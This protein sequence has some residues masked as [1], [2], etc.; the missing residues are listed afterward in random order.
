MLNISLYIYICLINEGT[1]SFECTSEGEWF[2]NEHGEWA[3]YSNCLQSILPV[4]F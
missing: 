3:D 2:K 1:A 4:K